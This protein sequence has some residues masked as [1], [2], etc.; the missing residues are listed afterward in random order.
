MLFTTPACIIT[1]AKDRGSAG[2]A[3]RLARGKLLMGRPLH[4]NTFNS[5]RL[6]S[7]Q[8]NAMQ[9][10]VEMKFTFNFGFKDSIAAPAPLL[11]AAC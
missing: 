11:F 1:Q 7:S 5:F 8:C 6:L 4:A 2:R 10:N 3:G 9:Y